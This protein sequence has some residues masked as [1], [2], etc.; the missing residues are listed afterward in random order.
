MRP[1]LG[2]VAAE[3]VRIGQLFGRRGPSARTRGRECRSARHRRSPPPWWRTPAGSAAH[4]GRRGIAHQRL[5]PERHL[6]LVL[7]HPALRLRLPDCIA[8]FAGLRFARAFRRIPLNCLV[9]AANCIDGSPGRSSMSEG[10]SG[11][12]DS[13]LRPPAPKAGALPDC[14]MP[15]CKE[16]GMPTRR[17]GQAVQKHPIQYWRIIRDSRVRNGLERLLLS[18]GRL[19]RDGPGI[20]RPFES[21]TAKL[22]TRLAC[23]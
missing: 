20:A 3:I 17:A 4:V 22:L 12:Q 14:A 8:V 5:D 16:A 7:Q 1:G 23:K 13:N 10:W 6:R 19:R 21:Y 9:A 18:V 11:Q 2:P 15:R